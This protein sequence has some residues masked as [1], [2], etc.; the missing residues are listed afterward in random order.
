MFRSLPIS[1]AV[2]TAVL[3]VAAPAA[4]AG[5]SGMSAGKVHYS[6]LSVMISL[7]KASPLLHLAVAR[8]QHFDA[9][10]L[11]FRVPAGAQASG[12]DKRLDYLTVTLEEVMVSGYQTSANV[13]LSLNFA[14]IADATGKTMAAEV[15][16]STLGHAGGA[17]FALADGSV[18][19]VR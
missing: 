18:R 8:G 4:T 9:V 17:N 16:A 11:T 5:S 12:D 19:F 15:L 14:R 7:E 2:A 6:D 10:E 3:A 13:R 1:L